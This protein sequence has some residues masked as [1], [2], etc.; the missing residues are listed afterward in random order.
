MVPCACGCMPASARISVVL[1]APLAPTMA[2]IAPSS[3]SSDTRVE[4]LDVAVEHIEVFDAQHH[5][6]SSSI[7]RAAS[8]DA[9]Q[10]SDWQRLM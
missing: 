1:P 2:T 8:F 7:L 3:M 10:R 9:R 5:R 6:S 4:R